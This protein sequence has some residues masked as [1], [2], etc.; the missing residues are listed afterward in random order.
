[1]PKGPF[2]GR[3]GF[4]DSNVEWVSLKGQARQERNGEWFEGCPGDIWVLR[5]YS[6][7]P[8]EY[9]RTESESPHQVSPK[10]DGDSERVKEECLGSSG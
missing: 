2:A 6:R 3:M 8:A 5:Q 9:P 4:A 7:I 1:M 10:R